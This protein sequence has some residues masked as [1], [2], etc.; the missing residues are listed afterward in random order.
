MIT[1]GK[2]IEFVKEF[3]P[4][5]MDATR[6]NQFQGVYSKKAAQKVRREIAKFSAALQA[7]LDDKVA[8]HTAGSVD[9]MISEFDHFIEYPSKKEGR[10][11]WLPTITQRRAA[12]LIKALL[13][14]LKEAS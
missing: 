10:P 4:K 14:E 11:G 13:L 9:K 1:K 3:T 12:P 8:L 7:K 6:V 5:L 2:A